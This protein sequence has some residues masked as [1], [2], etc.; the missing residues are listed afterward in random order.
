MHAFKKK[1]LEVVPEE[2]HDLD[3]PFT[4]IS[5]RYRLLVS[6]GGDLASAPDLDSLLRSAV[7][8]LRHDLSY[9]GARIDVISGRRELRAKS[10]RLF[11]LD[12]PTQAVVPVEFDGHT[13]A[14]IIIP[15]RG[16]S[17][18]SNLDR[19][20]LH[21]F[22]AFLA[23]GIRNVQRLEEFRTLASIDALT[24][25][26]N[27]RKLFEIGRQQRNPTGATGLIVFDIDWLKRINDTFGHQAG[28]ALLK[29]IAK[30]AKACIRKTDF[31]VR[32][33]GDE[34]VILL[35]NTEVECV[36]KVAE[37][38]RAYVERTNLEWNGQ[39]IQ[40]TV[41][42]GAA[43]VDGQVDIHSLLGCADDALL[44][45]KRAGRNAVRIMHAS[46]P[47]PAV[48]TLNT[49]DQTLLTLRD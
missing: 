26:L 40:S 31:L 48:P 46:D 25:V 44:A 33:G 8:Y 41:S 21:T 27:R 49:S 24:G 14:Q 6:I 42:V 19:E 39:P 10:G 23:V 30:R 29:T 11:T 15:L 34:F 36:R 9:S 45:A 28:D 22:A 18:L 13:L 5:R 7:S 32:Y 12:L 3:Q 16:R 38:V 1:N 2:A 4:E 17:G 43:C 20:V 37:R 47:L 35:P